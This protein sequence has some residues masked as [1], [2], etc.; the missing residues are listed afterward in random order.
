MHSDFRSEEMKPGWFD[1]DNLPF[2]SM[3]RA[4]AVVWRS[5]GFEMLKDQWPEARLYLPLVLGARS[6]LSQTTQVV[7][8][9]QYAED[10]ARQ[11]DG[12]TLGIMA[13]AEGF[14]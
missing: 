12:W 1:V 10:C 14:N 3:V 7:G 9:F 13:P 8:R 11:L 4:N 5:G 2:D 6:R